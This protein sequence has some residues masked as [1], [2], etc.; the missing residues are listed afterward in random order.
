MPLW[1]AADTG[2][3][4]VTTLRV[5][6][7]L[8]FFFFFFWKVVFLTELWLLRRPPWSEGKCTFITVLVV[9]CRL[10][11][12]VYETVIASLPARQ[13]AVKF[14]SPRG[15]RE[16]WVPWFLWSKTR[17]GAFPP[18]VSCPPNSERP[19]EG[20]TSATSCGYYN[21]DTVPNKRAG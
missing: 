18:R 16:V 21:C 5:L 14:L 10:A 6:Y 20:K 17:E 7:P 2:V 4:S 19:E 12:A 9:K 1:R 13:R 8:L 15:E 11:A 3:F